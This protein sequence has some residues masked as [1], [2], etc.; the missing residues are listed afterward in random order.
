M[1]EISVVHVEED[2]IVAVQHNTNKLIA[3]QKAV[4]IEPGT[5]GAINLLE[6]GVGAGKDHPVAALCSYRRSRAP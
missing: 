4:S 2:L 6:Q 5:Y 3:S 1:P